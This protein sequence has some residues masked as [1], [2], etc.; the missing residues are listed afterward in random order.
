MVLLSMG[1][2]YHIHE[3][4]MHRKEIGDGAVVG[5]CCKTQRRERIV[6]M[7]RQQNEGKDG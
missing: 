4:T 6:V 3:R 2:G 7:V 5:V 1:D